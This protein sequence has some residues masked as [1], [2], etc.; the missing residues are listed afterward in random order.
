[1]D[2][3]LTDNSRPRL[4]GGERDR[5]GLSVLLASQDDLRLHH[6][7]ERGELEAPRAA[8]RLHD[9][10]AEERHRL[11]VGADEADVVDTIA[12]PAGL[13]REVLA[14]AGDDGHRQLAEPGLPAN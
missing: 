4:P 3:S 12:V 9:V 5:V 11:P 10:G 6:R 14:T 1:M 2:V 7:A 13:E 8:G